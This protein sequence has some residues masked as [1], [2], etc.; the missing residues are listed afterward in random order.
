M[1]GTTWPPAWKKAV[2]KHEAKVK[3]QALR[4]W[5]AGICWKCD[6]LESGTVEYHAWRYCPIGSG[7]VE[8]VC[9]AFNELK[10]R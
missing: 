6:I 8:N 9:N 2:Q 4:D 1:Y 3:L 10:R 5:G 7:P